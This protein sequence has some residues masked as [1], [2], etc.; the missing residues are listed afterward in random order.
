[1]WTVTLPRGGKGSLVRQDY[2]RQAALSRVNAFVTLHG[3]Q[4]SDVVEVECCKAF[5][6][7]ASSYYN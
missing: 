6:V 4:Q 7:D 5:I 2:T 1:M 3:L